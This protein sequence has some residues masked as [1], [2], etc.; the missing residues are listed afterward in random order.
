ML[1]RKAKHL[2]L[3]AKNNISSQARFFATLRYAHNDRLLYVL[4]IKR[5]T[6]ISA[7]E[8]VSLSKKDDIISWIMHIFGG[9]MLILA[10]KTAGAYTELVGIG[11]KL[12]QTH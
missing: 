2:A 9:I 12:V 5:L 10:P 11:P 4:V 7:I 3:I 8:P 1:S 6:V